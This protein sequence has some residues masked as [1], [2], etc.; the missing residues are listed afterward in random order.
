MAENKTTDALA[1]RK[2][3]GDKWKKNFE[4][5]PEVKIRRSTG[6]PYVF[7]LLGHD[8]K[9]IVVGRSTAHFDDKS[10]NYG[11]LIKLY[12]VFSDTTSSIL[13]KQVVNECNELNPQTKKVVN[14]LFDAMREKANHLVEEAVVIPINVSGTDQDAMAVTNR[15]ERIIGNLVIFGD[16]SGKITPAGFGARNATSH[17]K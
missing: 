9:I 13:A 15:L 8:K 14:K 2:T 3:E 10:E 12:K 16:E 7:I 17:Q 5:V 11:D 6:R 4:N 1:L